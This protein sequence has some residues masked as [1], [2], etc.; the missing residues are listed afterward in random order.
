MLLSRIAIGIH[1]VFDILAGIVL[2]TGLTFVVI[3]AAHFIV[4]RI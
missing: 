2:G 3:E 4:E 1:Y